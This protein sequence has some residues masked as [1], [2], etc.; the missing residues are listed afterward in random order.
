MKRLNKAEMNVLVKIMENYGVNIK[1]A[2][3]MYE[4]FNKTFNAYRINLKKS[5][6]DK[7][8]TADAFI[9]FIDMCKGFKCGLGEIKGII[10][11]IGKA[12]KSDIRD[13]HYFVEKYEYYKDIARKFNVRF[14]KVVNAYDYF[15]RM[16]NMQR[17]LN[18]KEALTY[19]DMD[20]FMGR[21]LDSYT[22]LDDFLNDAKGLE[23][24]KGDI[25]KMARADKP[26]EE[27]LI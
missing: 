16:F 17:E 2:S 10:E 26:L 5:E 3:D 15:R 4:E 18:R 21:I 20:K 27:L 19:N 13:P 24:G 25:M 12:K 6:L 1:I 9:D 8:S 7:N 14:Y 11:L 22:S 23:E